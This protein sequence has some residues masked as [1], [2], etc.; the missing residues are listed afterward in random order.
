MITSVYKVFRKEASLG[1]A[2]KNFLF[3]FFLFFFFCSANFYCIYEKNTTRIIMLI[4][5]CYKNACQNRCECF[6][7][8]TLQLLKKKSMK[9][10]L[11]L[12]LSLS[13]NSPTTDKTNLQTFYRPTGFILDTTGSR[14]LPF[15]R[16]SRVTVPY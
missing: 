9:C 15:K 8:F 13:P 10:S 6:C 1:N 7:S 12:P 11:S 2:T 16:T 5:F 14:I 3:L 4:C